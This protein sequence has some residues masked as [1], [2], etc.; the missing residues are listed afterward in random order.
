MSPTIWTRCAASCR[1]RAHAFDCLRLVESQHVIATRKLVDSDAEQ[2]LLESLIALAKPPVPS[3]LSR[4]HYLLFTPFRHPPLQNGSRFGRRTEPGLFYG[5]AEVEVALAEVAYYRL[6]FLEGTRATLPL[7]QSEHTGFVAKVAAKQFVDL[8]KPPFAAFS[9]A[10]HS[11]TDYAPSQQLGGE[12]RAA[13]IDAFA[14]DS[15]RAPGG[16]TNY[17]LLAPVFASSRPT[18]FRTWTCSATKDLVEFR[19]RNFLKPRALSFPR[20]AF[21]CPKALP[22]PAI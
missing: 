20:A 3:G 1:P 13:G 6:V 17:G 18:R 7:L 16:G 21:L 19:E 12:L 9:E 22:S 11:K 5:S 15:A 8:R 10:I 2:A 4:L 14:Y